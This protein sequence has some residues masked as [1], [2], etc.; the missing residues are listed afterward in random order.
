MEPSRSIENL[1]QKLL[2]CEAV[3]FGEF[4]LTSGKTSNFYVDMKLASTDPKILKLISQEFAKLL[5]KDIDFIAGMELGAVP[6]AVGLSLETGIP[7]SMIRKS[8]REHGTSSRIEGLSLGRAV[9]VDDV[10]TTGG[11]NVESINVL[12]SEGVNVVMV[13]VVVDREEGASEK[14]KPFNIKYNSLINISDLV[15]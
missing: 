6:L 15:D 5:P 11:S 1:K 4:T 7:Y 13:L 3:K 10:A 14:I 2:K 8:G 9:L 12:K